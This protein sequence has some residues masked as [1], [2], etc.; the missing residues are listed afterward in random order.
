MMDGDLMMIASSVAH[1][2]DDMHRSFGDS[3]RASA[4]SGVQDVIRSRHGGGANYLYDS[5]G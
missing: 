5:G 4:F 2:R 1:R 3:P